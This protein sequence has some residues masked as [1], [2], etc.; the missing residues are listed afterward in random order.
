LNLDLI[1]AHNADRQNL[2][3]ER[4]TR[5]GFQCW[6]VKSDAFGDWPLI[7]AIGKND[8]VLMRWPSTLKTSLRFRYFLNSLQLHHQQHLNVFPELD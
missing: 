5:H 2:A 6:V 3:F 7:V 1:H 8:F 4:T